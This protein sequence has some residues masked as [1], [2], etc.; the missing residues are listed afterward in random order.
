[1]RLGLNHVTVVMVSS[2]KRS[3]FFPGQ[4]RLLCCESG[5]EGAPVEMAGTSE[6]SVVAESTDKDGKAAE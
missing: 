6:G 4:V 1:M 2:L 5:T 3:W